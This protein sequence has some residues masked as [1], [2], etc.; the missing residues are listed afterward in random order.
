MLE[1]YKFT[2]QFQ[3]AKSPVSYV[4]MK[5]AL[6]IEYSRL[7][8]QQGD[9]VSTPTGTESGSCPHPRDPMGD[10]RKGGPRGDATE[11]TSGTPGGRSRTEP[12]V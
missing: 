9:I 2:C 12:V 1:E 5:E 7:L 11:L 3:F 10:G 4:D 6:M 8:S